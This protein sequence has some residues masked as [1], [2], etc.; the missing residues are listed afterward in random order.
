MTQNASV[1]QIAGLDAVHITSCNLGHRS[2]P[3]HLWDKDGFGYYRCADCGL[4]WVSP[5]LT[6]ESV[7]HIYKT[8]FGN[9][10]AARQRPDNFNVYQPILEQI[11]PYRQNNRL[12]DVGC[13]TGNFLLAAREQGWQVE[14][15]EVSERAIEIATSEYGL[16]IHSGDLTSL[17][18]PDNYYDVVTLSDVIEHVSDPLATIRQIH[19]ILRP[20]GI[21]YMDT[22]HFFSIPYLI[23]K[24]QWS[25]FFPWHRTYFSARNMKLALELA[26][27]RVQHIAAIGVLPMQKHNAW[28]SY[29]MAATSQAGSVAIKNKP[30]V[31]RYKHLLRPVWLT[32]KRL[33]YLPFG[34]LS[35]LGMYI[36]AK[37][38]VYAV[39]EI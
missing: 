26:E 29:Q 34:I 8:V 27:F 15:T 23:F 25:V 18:L 6:D 16:T 21:L 1:T 37:L 12:L 17:D 30:L 9:K 14:G 20:G 33:H 28:K 2:E 10:H 19:R 36:G 11:Q 5:Q 13:F 38:V 7:A 35:S 24:Q 31:K 39:K 22:P 32:F 4:V 3:E